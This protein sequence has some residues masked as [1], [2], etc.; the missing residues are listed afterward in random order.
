MKVNGTTCASFPEFPIAG[1]FYIGNPLS[2][3]QKHLSEEIEQIVSE[4]GKEI[5]RYLL[6]CLQ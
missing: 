4:H 1:S 6:T 5:K 2:S 3:V